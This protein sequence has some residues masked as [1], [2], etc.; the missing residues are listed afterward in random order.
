MYVKYF[1]FVDNDENIKL[2]ILNTLQLID[3]TTE[4]DKV[5]NII[6]LNDYF[7]CTDA[8]FTPLSVAS[9]DTFNRKKHKYTC[10]LWFYKLK[11]QFDNI[12]ES[13]S[14]RSISKY[15]LDKDNETVY[16]LSD[17]WGHGISSCNWFLDGYPKNNKE[18]ALAKASLKDFKRNDHQ[19]V[20]P[21]YLKTLLDLSEKCLK[22][23]N[24]KESMI[25]FLSDRFNTASLFID[26]SK[27]TIYFYED[28]LNTIID[29]YKS[30]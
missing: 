17:H 10:E 6:S 28:K 22:M 15:I 20:N 4:A 13:P 5:N 7:K 19:V 21:L 1:E 2:S 16:R 29:R 14:L 11:H 24:D 3:I 30:I 8:T 9:V 12:T 26:I 18:Y 27:D 23:C 25:N